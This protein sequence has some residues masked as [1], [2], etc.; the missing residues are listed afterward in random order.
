MLLKKK[1][2]IDKANSI[3]GS[4]YTEKWNKLYH[5]GKK[6]ALGLKGVL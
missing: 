3:I 2:E 6:V 5:E 4:E 1:K